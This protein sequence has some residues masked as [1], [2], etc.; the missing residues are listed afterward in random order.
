M[1]NKLMTKAKVFL[2]KKIESL[3]KE[4]NLKDYK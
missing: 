2:V 3:E 1:K 4:V